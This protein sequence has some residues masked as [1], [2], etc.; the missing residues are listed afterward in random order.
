MIYGSKDTTTIYLRLVKNRM[1]P[2]MCY[3][4]ENVLI[5]YIIMRK[6]VTLSK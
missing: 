5:I 2:Q 6:N 1:A 4:N 3:I